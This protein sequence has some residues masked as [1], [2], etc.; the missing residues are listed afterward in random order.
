M[1]DPHLGKQDKWDEV[2]D[3][4][5]S[6]LYRAT[7]AAEPPVWLDRRILAAARTAVEPCPTSSIPLPRRRGFRFWGA[8]VALAATVV[9]AV[10][11]LRWLPPVGELGGMATPMEEKAARSLAQPATE[12]D[13]ARA[14]SADTAATP[15][16]APPPPPS[17]VRL[18]EQ[19]LTRPRAMPEPARSESF[20]AAPARRLADE[21]AAPIQQRA[22]RRSP[23]AWRAEI[24]ELRRQGRH[25]EAEARLAEFRRRYPHEPLNDAEPP[26]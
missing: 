7:R 22:N 12:S 16:A 11:L 4:R 21:E 19:R 5:L 23:A 6:E 10:G 3:E 15:P 8:P 18:D 20:Q 1:N 9:L 26:R 17:S 24:A 14:K 2:H 25:A 13:G